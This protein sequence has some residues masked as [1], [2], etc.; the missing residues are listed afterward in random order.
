[1]LALRARSPRV[2]VMLPELLLVPGG[3]LASDSL[4]T[5]GQSGG[6][7]DN[8]AVGGCRMDNGQ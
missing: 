5:V 7:K 3:G 2:G 1:M 6:G 4:Q 8:G